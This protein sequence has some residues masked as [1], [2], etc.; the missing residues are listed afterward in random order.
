MIQ[1]E[2]GVKKVG[3]E[4]AQVGCAVAKVDTEEMLASV[5]G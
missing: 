3:K 5:N 1:E 2:C 4:K